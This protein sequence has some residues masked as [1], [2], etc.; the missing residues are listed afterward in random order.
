MNTLRV[1][2]IDFEIN[3]KVK[4]NFFYFRNH[5]KYFRFDNI[6]G[7]LQEFVELTLSKWFENISKKL[8]QEILY[9]LVEL[10]IM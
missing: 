3:N 2:N 5:L 8:N 4:D 9:F 7:G 10:L 6:A 1:K